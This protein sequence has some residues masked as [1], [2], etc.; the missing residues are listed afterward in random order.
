VEEVIRAS[1]GG[2]LDE[3]ELFDVYTGAPIPAGHRNLAYA[4]TF[5]APDR[6][7]AAEEVDRVLAAVKRA[8]EQRLRAKIRE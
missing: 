5:R 2:W 8:L 4:L 6:T 3:V 7:L 1:G